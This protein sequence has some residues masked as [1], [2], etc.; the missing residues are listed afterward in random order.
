MGETSSDEDDAT[1]R[2]F[3]GA[4]TALCAG[5]DGVPAVERGRG[6]S[7]GMLAALAALALCACA[8][9]E[10]AREQAV[11]GPAALGETPR[12]TEISEPSDPL[13]AV[14]PL[15]WN[16]AAAED[17]QSCTVSAADTA[18]RIVL[19]VKDGTPA[20]AVLLDITEPHVWEKLEIDDR[21]S[22]GART[23]RFET[24]PKL[25]LTT[26]A[27]AVEALLAGEIALLSWAKEEER[28]SW[29]WSGPSFETRIVDLR[30]LDQAYSECW[31]R[32]RLG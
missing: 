6:A 10:P 20:S 3:H 9:A 18:L 5:S 14:E 23:P 11:P 27:S 24:S 30:G 15:R 17:G 32:L 2:R 13:L 25:P 8:G 28:G 4:V 31:H 29:L 19:S 26:E 22:Y 1:G 7:G 12:L 16:A 21:V